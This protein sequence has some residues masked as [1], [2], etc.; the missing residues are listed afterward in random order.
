MRDFDCQENGAICRGDFANFGNRD[1][2][3]IS[4][5]LETGNLRGEDFAYSDNV[6]GARFR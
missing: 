5:G 1:R 2:C 6:T 3:A 4:P